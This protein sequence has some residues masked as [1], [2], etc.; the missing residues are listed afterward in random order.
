VAADTDA[1]PLRHWLVPRAGHLLTTPRVTGRLPAS[2]SLGR[3]FSSL[4]ICRIFTAS[5]CAGT[6]GC[7]RMIDVIAGGDQPGSDAP[8]AGD[9]PA[10]APALRPSSPYLAAQVPAGAIPQALPKPA[11]DSRSGQPPAA[12]AGNHIIHASPA[13]PGRTQPGP[14]LPRPA[15]RRAERPKDPP[16]TTQRRRS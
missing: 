4:L 3:A 15:V 10:H 16:L 13:H 6:V 5:L 14:W 12:Q 2:T 1:V 11:R 8:M 9:D 7:H